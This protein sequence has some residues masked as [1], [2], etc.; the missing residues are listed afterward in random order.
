MKTNQ[1]TNQCVAELVARGKPYKCALVA[2]MR[3]I[4]L[5]MQSLLK[6]P[7]FALA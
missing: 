2:A 4:L 3:K 1:I 6:N 7:D 5:C